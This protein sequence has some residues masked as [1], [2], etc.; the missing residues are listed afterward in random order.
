MLGGLGLEIVVHLSDDRL[1]IA[2][3][4]TVAERDQEES[5]A[6]QRQ[7]PR[8]VLRCREDRN[9]ENHIAQRHNDETFL[10]GSLVV[11][12]AVGDDT[13]HKAE[14]VYSSIEE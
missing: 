12:R 9:G 3:E 14:N 1:K 5:E 8:L 11:L 4:Q 13:S 7:Q 10:D 2:L 6:G